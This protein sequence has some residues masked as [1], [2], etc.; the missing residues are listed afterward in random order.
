MVN[1]LAS[2]PLNAVACASQRVAIALLVA[3]GLGF[4]ARSPVA[5]RVDYTPIR[6]VA[7][8]SSGT[9]W[10]AGM[11]G[12]YQWSGS[13]WI[14]ASVT[15]RQ[16]GFVRGVWNGPGG[17][18]VVAWG[19][20]PQE[21]SF[22]WYRGN[23]QKLLGK[24]EWQG[25]P[26]RVF[27]TPP[28]NVWVTINSAAIYR[29][30]PGER[31]TQPVYTFGPG[32]FFPAGGIPFRRTNF[33]PIEATADGAGRTWFWSNILGQFRNKRQ[34]RGFLIYDGRRFIYH[35]SIP[36][37][38]Q[39]PLTFF[40][41]GDKGHM[42][43]GVL[44]QG[45]YSISLRTLTANR[46]PDP[47]PEAFDRVTKVFSFR[48]D[49][50][51]VSAPFGPIT[52]EAPGHLFSSVLWRYRKGKWKKIL[53][54]ID[55]EVDVFGAMLR[56]LLATK[57]G[58]WLG[59]AASGMWFIPE[60]GDPRLINWQQG[61][62]LD[63]VSRLF[64]VG[65]PDVNQFLAVD[66][67]SEGALTF[68]PD[69]L[70]AR[71]TR[72]P[73]IQ[74][75]DPFRAIQPDRR[76]RLWGIVGLSSDSLDEWDGTSWTRHPLPGNVT[77]SW[78]SG[79]DVDSRGRVWLFPDC[80]AGATAIYDPAHGTWAEFPSYQLALES[81]HGIHVKFLNARE[82]PL[83]PAYGPG[84]QI[85]FS[86]ACNRI[87]YFDGTEWRSW[88][89]IEVPAPR[90]FPFS[91]PAFFDTLGHLA[92]DIGHGTWE[93][94]PGAD[95]HLITYEPEKRGFSRWFA[96]SPPGAPPSGCSSSAAS[97]L[98][99]DRLGRSWWIWKR[100]VYVGVAGMCHRVFSSGQAQPFI[101]RRALRGVLIDVRGNAFLETMLF[102]GRVG[103]CVV[104]SP[105][106]P[107]PGVS[108]RIKSLSPDSVRLNFTSPAPGKVLY[109]W[110]LDHG[111][112][113]TPDTQQT[114]VLTALPSGQHTIDVTAFDSDL[115][116]EAVPAS[117]TI[118][119]NVNPERRMAGLIEQLEAAANDDQRQA[120]VNAIERQPS[121]VAIP[122]L[123]SALKIA[124]S[125]ARWWITAALESFAQGSSQSL[126]NR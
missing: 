69:S 9:V 57:A 31:A 42:W 79:V 77:P 83:Q 46:L 29:L 121:A 47:E 49:T 85:A 66:L 40:G 22:A 75:I 1:P 62:P 117:A 63:T 105:P 101:D 30:Q 115:D 32:Q 38:P 14:R 35:G 94:S 33:C 54:G 53:P 96:P 41:R 93:V 97:S 15:H 90:G 100:N 17:G 48:G 106:G 36:G 58:I 110:R 99:T 19:A 118:D 112:W 113:S 125:T 67:E 88:N 104:Y 78:L 68:S 119:I 61:F 70:L 86:G 3:A 123:R 25:G 59:A 76:H 98:A 122:A 37:L 24:L 124:N 13:A 87:N 65:A 60:H 18:V 6:S 27:S 56:P 120:A 16:N 34:V 7:Q 50:Y 108:I 52:A 80:R 114:E 8:D 82:D 126:T 28:D 5:L 45:L 4:A 55:D 64:S 116:A 84:G 2:K 102:S 91:G 21:V 23:Q 109:S 39:R 44:N 10:A 11:N 92:V 103:E 26:L 81:Q 71:S 74:V 72:E 12:L 95:W 73:K 89:R 20:G 111:A 51:V 43:A 107:G